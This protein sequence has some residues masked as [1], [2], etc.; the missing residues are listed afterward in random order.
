MLATPRFSSISRNC[1][2]P[3][4][5]QLQQQ[6][7]TERTKLLDALPE[8]RDSAKL[9]QAKSQ[10]ESYATGRG[11]TQAELS[12][13]VD[14]RYLLVLNDAARAK[15]L[16]AQVDTLKAQLDGKTEAALKKVRAAPTQA[17][18]P[19]ARVARDPKVVALSESKQSF[20]KN[21]RNPD[22]QAAYAQALLNAGLGS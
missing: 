22:A 17:A 8:W 1:S 20:L 16:Q 14:H 3:R 7:S 13:L 12:Q 2:R 9:Q 21:A 15:D 19:G 18:Q 5:S 11:F 6:V 4:R 10:L